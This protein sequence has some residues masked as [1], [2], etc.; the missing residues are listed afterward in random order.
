MQGTSGF[1]VHV[2]DGSLGL[3]EH[4]PFDA[5]AVAAA[6]PR[7]PAA[8]WDELR[9]GRPDRAAAED[10]P[11]G[12]EPLRPRADTGRSAPARDVPARYVPLIS[13]D[14]DA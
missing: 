9:A 14:G 6:A 3:P 7:V 11:P 1:S 10:G 2:G 8:L 12:A 5:I 4:A 13:G